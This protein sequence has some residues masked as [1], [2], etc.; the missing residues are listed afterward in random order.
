M[1]QNNTIFAFEDAKNKISVSSRKLYLYLI[2]TTIIGIV[3]A[4]VLLITLLVFLAALGLSITDFDLENI[5]ESAET[6]IGSGL[7]TS[8]LVMVI[9]LVIAILALI[10]ISIMSYVQYYRLGTG[11]S[12]LHASDPRTETNRY[13]SFGIYGYVLA[14]VA[15]IFI[16]GTF[17]TVVTLLG[18][19]SLAFGVF[20]VYQLFQGYAE[21]GRFKGKHSIIL[22]IGIALNVVASITIFFND[23]GIVG[24]LVGFILMLIGFRNLS[25]DIMLVEPPKGEAVPKKDV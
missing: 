11:F 1:S 4:V 8:G 17:G 13:I 24:S 2:W 7:L 5:Y 19:V 20:L 9:L 25:R 3:L 22:F 16:P 18:N 12:K 23:F 6:L 10:I 21:Q 15:G 14:V